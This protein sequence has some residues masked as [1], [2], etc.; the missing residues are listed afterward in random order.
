ML[1]LERVSNNEHNVGIAT[2]IFLYF[3]EINYNA[4][5]K[6]SVCQLMKTMKLINNK[7]INSKNEMRYETALINIFGMW[8]CVEVGAH[9]KSSLFNVHDA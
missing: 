9:W 8:K 3:E 6:Y 2:C 4:V 1:G 7:E 5:V